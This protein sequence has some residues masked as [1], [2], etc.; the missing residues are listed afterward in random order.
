ML[1]ACLVLGC[2]IS[3]FAYRRQ[4]QDKLQ[5]AIF[6]GAVALATTIGI[7]LGVN[8]NLI[9]LGMIPWALCSA[10]VMSIFVHWMMR[11]SRAGIR[12][13]PVRF[14]MVTCCELESGEKEVLS[15]KC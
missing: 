9:M 15:T 3:S 4:E 11:C 13:R 14:S 7:A 1:G 10:M 8:S 12:E 2:A 6:V 5:T